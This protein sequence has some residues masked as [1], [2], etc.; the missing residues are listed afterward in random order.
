MFI[1]KMILSDKN[2]MIDATKKAL[3][4]ADKLSGS[5]KIDWMERYRLAECLIPIYNPWKQ[6]F[7]NPRLW[8]VL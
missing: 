4:L 3:K 7:K 2:D 6:V 5:F 1:R 8:I